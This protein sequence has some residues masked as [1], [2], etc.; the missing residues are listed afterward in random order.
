[1][2]LLGFS[3]VHTYLIVWC[4]TGPYVYVKSFGLH[5]GGISF[6]VVCYAMWY[7]AMWYEICHT[8]FTFSLFNLSFI[9]YRFL[10]PMHGS[11]HEKLHVCLECLQFNQ[12]RSGRNRVRVINL[13]SLFCSTVSC[14]KPRNGFIQLESNLQQLILC[15]ENL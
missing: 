1:M 9:S 13:L 4:N 8:H 12:K 6:W 7:F 15:R 11:L 5:L 2:S 3:L 10:L 14:S